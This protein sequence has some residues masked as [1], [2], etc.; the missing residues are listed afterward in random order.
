ME[1]NT[2]NKIYSAGY[3]ETFHGIDD[4]SSEFSSFYEKEP[5]GDV[6]SS[7]LYVLASGTKGTSSPEVTAR[8]TAKKILYEFFHSYDYVDANK[9]ALAM[10]TAN[11]EIYEYAKVQSD[12]MSASAIAAAVT[13]GKAT[14]A[15]VGTCRA[16]II[17]NGKV[18]QITEEPAVI[19]ERVQTGEVSAEEAYGPDGIPAGQALLG[20]AR[21]ITTDIYDGIEVRNGDILLLCSGSL[22]TFIGKKEI[23]E[24]VAD[25]SP[26][27]IVQKLIGFTSLQNANIPASAAAIRIYDSSSVDTMIRVDGTAPEDTDLNS[28][29][30]EIALIRKNKSRKHSNE[31]G[32]EKKKSK[33]PGIILG[34]LL[35]LLA[36]CG[37]IYAAARY[38]LLPDQVREKYLGSIVPSTATPTP[39]VDWVRETMW[40]LEDTV[41]AEIEEAVA[42]TVQAW[43]TQTPYPTFTPVFID[44]EEIRATLEVPTETPEAG[45]DTDGQEDEPVAPAV[46][47]EPEEEKQ[48]QIVKDNYT[49][50]K[51]GA[52]MVYIPAG[53][54]LLGSDLSVDEYAIEGEET[55]Q[56]RIHLDGYWIGKT[57][58]TNAQY[59][60]CVEAGYCQQGGYMSLYTPEYQER[61]V[62]YVTI[63]QAER[64]CSWIGGR[65]PSEYEWEKAARGTDGR[66]Y[67]WGSEVPTLDNDLANVPNYVDK[68]GEGYDLFP[69]GSFPKG[70]SPYG[71]MDM[72]G[73]AW[74]WTSTWFSEDYYASLAEEQDETKNIVRNPQGP[75]YGNMQVMR[76]GSCNQTEVNSFVSFMRTAS[77]SYLGMSSSYYVGFRCVVPDPDSANEGVT[78]EAIPGEGQR[79]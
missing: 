4:F 72:A 21:D 14:I 37:G 15:T 61:P 53:T 51:S 35:A 26:R 7:N 73:N 41:E 76:G 77:R 79:H 65:L 47:P 19:D 30:K 12:H 25:N 29:K 70:A 13:D 9:L 8:F 64:F 1:D 2:E 33:A 56:L 52:D 62:T 66:I 5:D 54:F 20:N 43:P 69:V 49:D 58:V 40:V 39:T 71:L 36:I 44:L 48:E 24:A 67:P 23:M 55:P 3:A 50:V 59:L 11:N 28:E 60:R 57:E 22:D 45:P 18:F 42:E 63:D 32:G 16:F 78:A 68:E 74:E 6:G 46:L 17:R 38:G 27:S 34:I 10:R 75:E 31:T